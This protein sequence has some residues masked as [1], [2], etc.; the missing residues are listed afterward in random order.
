MRTR[1]ELKSVR[2]V[3]LQFNNQ[4]TVFLIML[5]VGLAKTLRK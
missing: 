2:P 4:N 1:A 3:C 5:N